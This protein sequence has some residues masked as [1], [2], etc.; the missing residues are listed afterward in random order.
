MC[1]QGRRP[2]AR[3]PFGTASAGEEVDGP[4]EK[5]QDRSPRNSAPC[6]R[7]VAKGVSICSGRRSMSRG[8]WEKSCVS[9]RSP[10]KVGRVVI[11]LWGLQKE[12]L[13]GTGRTTPRSSNPVACER[14]R[15]RRRPAGRRQS[16]STQAPALS[17]SPPESPMSA[18]LKSKCAVKE[19][20]HPR[21][22][23]RLCT[24]T[25]DCTPTSVP[26]AAAH[27]A[28]PIAPPPFSSHPM[29]A[30]ELPRLARPPAVPRLTACPHVPSV[31]QLTCTDGHVCPS[32]F[33]PGS[34]CLLSLPLP[35]ALRTVP[36]S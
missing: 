16:P 5:L 20:L 17:G 23:S 19:G 36:R 34:S 24:P 27:P 15:P 28:G 25:G 8:E 12:R 18:R 14:A 3:A 30:S 29:A 32:P 26:S 10:G 6:H 22:P 13:S 33:P 9:P 2:P 35:A 4:S 1:L 21:E 7:R 31:R 11:H